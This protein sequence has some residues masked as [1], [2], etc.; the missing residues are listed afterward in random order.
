MDPSALHRRFTD[1]PKPGLGVVY[2]DSNFSLERIGKA[3]RRRSPSSST[4]RPSVYR[5]K[6]KS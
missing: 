1:A 6:P 2:D 3:A 5:R 4:S